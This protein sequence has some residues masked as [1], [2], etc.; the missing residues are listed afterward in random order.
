MQ[1]YFTIQKITTFILC[2]LYTFSFAKPPKNNTVKTIQLDQ[3]LTT[4]QSLF[5]QIS[6]NGLT[7]PSYLYGTIHIIPQDDFFVGKNITKKLENTDELVMEVDLSKMDIVSIAKLSLLDSNKTIKDYLNDSDYTTLLN[8]M[9]DTI[10]IDINMFNL[11]YARMKPFYV[12]QLLFI[13]HIGQERESYEETFKAISDKKNISQ[14]GLETFEEQLKF[15]DEIPLEEQFQSLVETIKSYNTQ[16]KKL[17]KLVEDY[18]KQDLDAL[19][20]SFM[21]EENSKLKD[22]LIDKRNHKWIPAIMELTKNKSCFIA[23]GAGHL[24]G[25]NGIIQL[26]KNQGYTVE[27]IPIN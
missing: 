17:D 20:A 26:L 19:T 12:E 3:P 23:V 1:K 5:W 9:T 15:I 21:D 13:N 6:G 25:E 4:N 7:K 8:F 14:T 24:G 16:V 18:K 2:C 22:K 11:A 27:P 10:G